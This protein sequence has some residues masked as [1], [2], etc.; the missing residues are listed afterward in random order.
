[1]RRERGEFRGVSA[2]HWIPVICLIPRKIVGQAEYLSHSPWT[3]REMDA[4]PAEQ[5]RTLT[6]I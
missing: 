1:M 6:V 2:E 3:D 4:S 5:T